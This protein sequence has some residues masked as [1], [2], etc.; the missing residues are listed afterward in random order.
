[1]VTGVDELEVGI[2]WGAEE[3]NGGSVL[4]VTHQVFLDLPRHFLTKVGSMEGFKNLFN[5]VLLIGSE[6]C[7]QPF[8]G[9]DV[10]PVADEVALGVV[11]GETD[12][13]ALRFG[14]AF[15]KLH[16]QRVGVRCAGTG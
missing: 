11:N 8:F 10:P 2:L 13:L 9:A 16:R 3:R 6:E 1:M 7:V 14:Q 15:I 12:A 4:D 5:K